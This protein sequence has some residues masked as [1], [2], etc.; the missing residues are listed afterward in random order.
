MSKAWWCGWTL[1]GLTL[2]G[3][4]SSGWAEDSG[5]SRLTAREAQVFQRICAECHTR[6]GI[7]VPVI[8]DEEE[9]QARRVKG[10]DELL[11]NAVNGLLGMPPLGTCSFCT[12]EE[13]RH[14]VA[15]LAGIPLDLE[16]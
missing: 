4:G 5:A 13:L 10:L 2:V 8:G 12:E 14:L 16:E 9:W 1:A 7:G 11:A 3:I 6:P 15:F